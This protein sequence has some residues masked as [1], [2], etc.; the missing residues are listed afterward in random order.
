M[1]KGA[2]RLGERVAVLSGVFACFPVL[3]E[4]LIAEQL[5]KLENE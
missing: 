1:M 3:V 2:T 5:L 4:V